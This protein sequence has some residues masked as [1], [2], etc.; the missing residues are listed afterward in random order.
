VLSA[1]AYYKWSGALRALGRVYATG[2]LGVSPDALVG[3]DAVMRTLAYFA[4]IWPALAFGVLLGAAVRTFLPASAVS[5]WLAGDSARPTLVGA[6]ASAPLM[7]CSCCVSPVF[8]G[9]RAR[10]ARLGPSL[11]VML[12]SP[13]LNVAAIALTYALLPARVAVTRLVA[14]LVVVLGVSTLVDRTMDDREAACA[15]PASSDDAPGSWSDAVIRFLKSV[16]YVTAITVPL[17]A[18]GVVLS[19]MLLPYVPGLGR[20]GVVVA[21]AVVALVGMLVALPTFV[22]IPIAIALLEVGAPIGAVIAFVVAGPIINLPSLLVLA[23]ETRPRVALTLAAGVW[24]AATAAG[25]SA[26]L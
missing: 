12:G 6:V 13:G 16:A 9:V 3:G 11:A 4:R 19:S 25:L 18:V 8:T 26:S 21:V 15:V 24:V 22:E 2:R 20:G 23:R 5:R 7:L 1:L 10:G 14:A 17:I